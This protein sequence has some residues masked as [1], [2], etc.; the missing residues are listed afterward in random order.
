L[1]AIMTVTMRITDTGWIEAYSASVPALLADY[2]AT[3]VA[4]ARGTI[5]RIEGEG[6]LPDRIAVFSFPS[7]DA[8]ERFMADPRYQPFVALRASGAIS[9]IFA[10][11]NA[12][13]SGKLV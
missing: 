8:I 4:S 7:M 5:R 11:D 12:A 9:D 10:F 3:M 2:G 13:A 6:V 1:A